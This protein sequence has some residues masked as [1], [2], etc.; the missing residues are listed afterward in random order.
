MEVN[1][2]KDR[3][4]SYICSFSVMLMLE[5]ISVTATAKI[6]LVDVYYVIYQLSCDR[7]QYIQRK[8][9]LNGQLQQN[10][11]NNKQ[12]AAHLKQ[13]SQVLKAS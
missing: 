7:N 9:M 1:R 11:A 10:T 8:G 4:T 6:C 12:S 13:E 5:V 3:V 2:L